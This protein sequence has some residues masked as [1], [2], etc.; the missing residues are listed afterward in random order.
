MHNNPLLHT[1]QKDQNRERR[2]SNFTAV[3]VASL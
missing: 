3:T 2:K 1:Q